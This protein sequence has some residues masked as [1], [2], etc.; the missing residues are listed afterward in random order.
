[1]VK[2][3]CVWAWAALS[4]E[5]LGPLLTLLPLK[6]C[7]RP[8]SSS[9]GMCKARGAAIAVH[10]SAGES[11]PCACL[12]PH[13]ALGG[14]GMLVCQHGGPM[15]RFYNT[16]STAHGRI[17]A[18]SDQHHGGCAPTC[19]KAECSEGQSAA[20]FQLA[21]AQRKSI[22]VLEEG[23]ETGHPGPCP[24]QCGGYSTSKLMQSS[25]RASFRN[26][27]YKASQACALAA[28]HAPQCATECTNPAQARQV[29]R[30]NGDSG[31]PG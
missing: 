7:R 3:P 6:C 14:G 2:A 28:R 4:K 11:A 17:R 21:A 23:R 16:V 26:L 18:I 20:T 29:P 5:P 19:S 8:N 13:R 25:G 9:G 24:M 1:M 31:G 10:R 22:A 27:I 15:C 12:N 30:F